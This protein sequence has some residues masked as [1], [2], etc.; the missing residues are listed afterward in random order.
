MANVGAH[1]RHVK[2]KVHRPVRSH[3]FSG[4]LLELARSR[5]R[6]DVVAQQ[7]LDH[8]DDGI[9]EAVRT[10]DQVTTLRII[11][12][13]PECLQVRDSVG[14]APLHIAFLFGHYEL[15]KQMLLRAKHLATITYTSFDPDSPSAYEGENVLHIAIVHRQFALAEWLVQEVPGLLSAETTGKF[16]RPGKP[17]YFGGYPLL[18]AFASNQINIARS[19]LRSVAGR[20]DAHGRSDRDGRSPSTASSV[21]TSI[22]LCDSYG[23]NVLHLAVIHDLP[24]VFNF[25]LRYAMHLLSGSNKNEPKH[26][27][28]VHPRPSNMEELETK[29]GEGGDDKADEHKNC[30]YAIPELANTD[31]HANGTGEPQAGIVS[32]PPIVFED[33]KQADAMNGADETEDVHVFS[34]LKAADDL[35]YRRMLAFLMQRNSDELT[36]LSLAAAIGNERMFRHLL[37]LSASLAWSYGPIRAV[38]IPLLDLEQ[39]MPWLEDGKETKSEAE[40]VLKIL[41]RVVKALPYPFAPKGTTGYATALQCLCS[42]ERLSNIVPDKTEARREVISRR[43]EMLKLLE[44]KQLLKKKWKYVGK[45]RF[46]TRLVVYT[47]FLVMLNAVTLFRHDTYTAGAIGN[48][49]LL[50]IAESCCLGVTIVKFTNEC[51]QMILHWKAYMS[52]AGAG[53]LDNICTVV[54]GISLFLSVFMRML[55]LQ[56]PEDALVAITLIFSWFYL[57]FFLMGFRSTGPFVIM[58]LRMIANDIVRFMFVYG[59]VMLGFAQAVY[60][61]QDARSG[62]PALL[63][64]VRMLAIAGFTGEVNYDDNYTSGRMNAFTQLLMLAYILLVMILLVNLLIAM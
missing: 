36:P 59:A 61:V 5:S 10:N 62:L 29:K 20:S 19:I 48:Q 60:V 22:F 15:G 57:L 12:A 25:A 32:K 49:I 6:V 50:G 42:V 44:V 39:P 37:N 34:F 43:L 45:R 31:V 51:S 52:E 18:F 16:F 35:A 53:R 17:C 47:I 30:T 26:S 11:D 21:E 8:D 54:T 38:N 58:I 40:G 2:V 4:K 28:H 14:A 24:S 7:V 13:N 9:F 63:H 55:G 23:N 33:T 27:S 64:R 56:D 41:R 3:G 1:R 46:M